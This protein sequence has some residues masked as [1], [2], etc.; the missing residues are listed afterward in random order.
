MNK[1][2]ANAILE[3][4]LKDKLEKAGLDYIEYNY[5]SLSVKEAKEVY[6]RVLSLVEWKREG[7]S[8]E[9]WF[10]ERGYT[11]IAIPI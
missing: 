11:F 5:C 2:V 3:I 8:L 1:R 6:L 4:A 10:I 7:Y 9:D